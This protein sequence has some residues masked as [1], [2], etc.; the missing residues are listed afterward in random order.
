MKI[1]EKADRTD[2]LNKDCCRLP[3]LAMGDLGAKDNQK[4]RR[5][6]ATSSS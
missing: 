5:K 6:I 2:L 4:P 1:E 3:P